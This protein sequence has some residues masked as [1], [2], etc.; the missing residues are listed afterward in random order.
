VIALIVFAVF[1]KNVVRAEDGVGYNWR[2]DRAL[3]E[4]RLEHMPGL[5]LVMVRYGADH[6]IEQEWVYNR[7]DIDHS[8]VVW[9]REMPNAADNVDLNAYFHDRMCWILE[10]DV[11]QLQLT[12]CPS[13]AVP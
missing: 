11:D 12:P 9:A 3:L 6:F 1:A 8:K 10:P 4:D 7:A 5:Q 2:F 13:L